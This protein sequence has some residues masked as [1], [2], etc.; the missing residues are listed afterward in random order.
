MSI[1]SQ[2]GGMFII[3]GYDEASAADFF[4]KNC[5]FSLFTYHSVGCITIKATLNENVVSPYLKFRMNKWKQPL[6]IILIKILLYEDTNE[7]QLKTIR[8]QNV[9]INKFE[10]S[11]N[12]SFMQEINNQIEIYK[13]TFLDKVSLLDPLC[14]ALLYYD[15]NLDKEYI[16]NLILLITNNFEGNNIIDPN[17]NEIV[18]LSSDDD[19]IE[20]DKIT[21]LVNFLNASTKKRYIN[22]SLIIMEFLDD[23]QPL[24]NYINDSKNQRLKM[25]VFI[26]FELLRLH[27]LGVMHNDLHAN[28]IFINLT[29]PYFSVYPQSA[30][31]GRAMIIDFGRVTT[32]EVLKE[33]SKTNTI[34]ENIINAIKIENLGPMFNT[35]FSLHPSWDIDDLVDEVKLYTKRRLN[36][37]TDTLE[38]I[39]T[40]LG[41]GQHITNI[42]SQSAYHGGRVM[43]IN[44]MNTMNTMNTNMNIKLQNKPMDS[45][46]N[47][48]VNLIK[49]KPID[50]IQNKPMDSI[51][52]APMDSKE[53]IMQFL[54]K[55]NQIMIRDIKSGQFLKDINQILKQKG[56][57][58]KIRK[59]KKTNKINKRTNKRNKKT[60]KKTN[61]K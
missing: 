45:I 34:K 20:I 13:N 39:N 9:R 3:S 25:F 57:Q 60:N 27:K 56:G 38:F 12:K 46:Q 5:K 48:S 54:E 19:D 18:E 55:N 28:N 11:N 58:K 8:L 31:A 32:S 59:I 29:E 2:K 30:L 61:K 23:F 26:L 49:N 47:K 1:F 33:K 22:K 35:I 37:A 44:E 50:S 36:I 53:D 52:N 24:S 7:S 21:L 43:N 14:P 15:K 40:N 10:I 51:Q 17:E 41:E 16:N 42:F 6:N 4:M